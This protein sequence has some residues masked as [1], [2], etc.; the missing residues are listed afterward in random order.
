VSPLSGSG[1]PI[2]GHSFAS[3]TTELRVPIAGK[4]GGVF[5]MDAGNVW[6]NPWDIN[7]NDLRYDIG[8]GLRYNTPVG[9]LRL[10]V[11]FQLN[12]I[13]GLIVDGAPQKRSFRIHFSIG[14][15]F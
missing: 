10:D 6:R 8:P 13:D 15:A 3:F 14:Q 12:P 2:G 7:L 5:F 9:P 11:G 4:L 1:L